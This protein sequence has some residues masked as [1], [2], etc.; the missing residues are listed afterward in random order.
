MTSADAKYDT[1]T[2][3]T[4]TCACADTHYYD[5]V[6]LHEFAWLPHVNFIYDSLWIVVVSRADFAKMSPS[7]DHASD[8]P[9]HSS[10]AEW[11]CNTIPAETNQFK[12][13]DEVYDLHNTDSNPANIK[14]ES[15]LEPCHEFFWNVLY[16]SICNF[17]VS[18]VWVSCIAV[19]TIVVHYIWVVEC[20]YVHEVA[21][22]YVRYEWV[23]PRNTLLFWI[24][25]IVSV[26]KVG[27][28]LQN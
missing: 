19:S 15:E 2:A 13:W 1:S 17:P 23:A 27:H 12:F 21:K 18:N 5:E 25:P 10:T 11:R 7:E 8:Q 16:S 9:C 4:D 3:A 24:L 6:D 22:H 28:F 26:I 20:V 14:N